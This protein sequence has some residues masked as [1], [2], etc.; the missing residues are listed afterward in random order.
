MA[1][2]SGCD[3]LANIKN[4]GIKTAYRYVRRYKSIE[5]VLQMLQ[6]E[7]KYYVPA[8]Y[9][10]DFKQAELT[11]LHQRGCL[12]MLQQMVILTGRNSDTKEE[13]LPFLWTPVEKV[14]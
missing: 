14:S 8:A 3:Y 11:F 12:P 10:E 4:M 13:D 9:L 6:F 5:K 2:L 7:G 1:I